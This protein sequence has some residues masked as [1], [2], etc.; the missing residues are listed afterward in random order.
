MCQCWLVH[1][2]VNL[3]PLLDTLPGHCYPV[4][5][6]LDSSEVSICRSHVLACPSH[7]PPPHRWGC[8][9]NRQKL[10]LI[11]RDSLVTRKAVSPAPSL[12]VGCWCEGMVLEREHPSCDLRKKFQHDVPPDEKRPDPCVI[13]EWTSHPDIISVNVLMIQATGS[14]IGYYL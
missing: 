12:F 5:F 4:A 1:E 3:S 8:E 14:W 9:R 13:T 10:P 7:L 11:L 6:S 2:R